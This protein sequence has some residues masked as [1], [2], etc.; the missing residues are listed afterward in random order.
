M[1]RRKNISNIV[2][3]LVIIA[4]ALRLGA[5]YG[6]LWKM[7]KSLLWVAAVVSSVLLIKGILTCLVKVIKEWRE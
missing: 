4:I 5:D 1:N 2:I 6:I 3:L 7:V